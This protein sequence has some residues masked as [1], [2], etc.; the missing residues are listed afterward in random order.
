MSQKEHIYEKK[1]F[2]DS[3]KNLK[4]RPK[5]HERKFKKGDENSF[6][7]KHQKECNKNE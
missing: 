3:A 7:H 4:T 1:Y 5:E 6:M 2:V